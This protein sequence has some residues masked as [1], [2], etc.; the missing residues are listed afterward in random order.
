MKL[1]KDFESESY[2]IVTSENIEEVFAKVSVENIYFNKGSQIGDFLFEKTDY[3]HPFVVDTSIENNLYIN[4]DWYKDHLQEGRNILRRIILKN[5]SESLSIL[6]DFLIDDSLLDSIKESGVVKELELG[7]EYSLTASVYEK[8]RGSSVECLRTKGVEEE[9]KDIYEPFIDYNWSRALIGWKTYKDIVNAKSIEIKKEEELAYLHLLPLDC[10]LVVSFSNE[11]LF[12]KVLEMNYVGPITIK[13]TDKMSFNQ[14]LKEH[15]IEKQNVFVSVDDEKVELPL[16]KKFEE[17]LDNM[18]KGVEGLSPFEKYLYVYNVVKQYKEYKENEEDRSSARNLY[19]IL[20]NEYMV[21]VGFS[22]MLVDLCTRV[23]I[24][25]QKS[26]LDVDTSYDKYDAGKEELEIEKSLRKGG[27]ARTQVYINDPKYQINGYYVA[28][29]TWDNELE[30]DSYLYVLM[31]VEE[32]LA[33][34]RFI[35]SDY[36]AGEEYFD[37]QNLDVFYAKVNRALDLLEPKKE[38]EVIVYDMIKLGVQG[39]K[40]GKRIAQQR[41]REQTRIRNL[42]KIIDII[43]GK[44]CNLS[45]NYISELKN[46]YPCIDNVEQATIHDYY[47]VI[48]ELGNHIVPMCNRQ[49]NGAD[50]FRAIKEVYTHCYGYKGEELSNKLTEAISYNK[51]SYDR[52]FPTRTREYQDGHTNIYKSVPNKFDIPLPP[53]FHSQLEAETVLPSDLSS[54]LGAEETVKLH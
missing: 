43:I 7:G 49:I 16:Y 6:S 38:E 53:S 31:T 35:L 15:S 30:H 33:A 28:D 13:V 44:L 50:L 18:V 51:E 4:E 25:A 39:K 3:E 42:K 9:L 37:C 45:P 29:A 47:D 19:Q 21:C 17:Q 32:R 14:F 46:Q 48:T 52:Q 40:N 26:H 23:G 24:P 1:I 10:E 34:R 12:N 22:E 27:H 20:Q 2:I 11:S 54:Q 36:L 8:L 41:K 5:Q